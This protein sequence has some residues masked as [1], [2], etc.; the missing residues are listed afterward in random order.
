[1]E[2]NPSSCSIGIWNYHL[3]PSKL[4]SRIFL[5]PCAC[6]LWYGRVF[7]TRVPTVAV[8][9]LSIYQSKWNIFITQIYIYK[10]YHAIAWIQ[11]RKFLHFKYLCRLCS[12]FSKA[13]VIWICCPFIKRFWQGFEISLG[14]TLSIVFVGWTIFR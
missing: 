4:K 5:C 2:Q 10:F 14:K 12:R 1:M 8:T 7:A 13:V 3:A 6:P 11:L 9:F